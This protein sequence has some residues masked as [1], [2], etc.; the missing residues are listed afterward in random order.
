MSYEQV[1]TTKRV[2]SK[3]FTTRTVCADNDNELVMTANRRGRDG[4]VLNADALASHLEGTK[5]VWETTVS[6]NEDTYNFADFCSCSFPLT[7]PRH[8]ALTTLTARMFTQFNGSSTGEGSLA[9]MSRT[10]TSSCAVLSATPHFFVPSSWCVIGFVD[11]RRR[12]RHSQT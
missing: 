12:H 7:P 9:C 8:T 4:D 2:F 3:S 10:G 6:Y 5:I 1:N 11:T